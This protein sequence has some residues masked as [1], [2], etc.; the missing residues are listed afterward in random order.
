MGDWS[1]NPHK[2]DWKDS[3]FE[4]CNKM[5]VAGAWSA[6]LLRRDL[7]ANTTVLPPELVFKVKLINE[8]SKYELYTQTCAN[9]S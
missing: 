1:K 7:L 9:G 3:F 8:E 5:N 4:N 6:P 2:A